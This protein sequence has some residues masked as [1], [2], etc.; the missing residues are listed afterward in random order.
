MANVL[1]NSDR[2]LDSSNPGAAL[3]LS[4]QAP[5]FLKK[6]HYPPPAFPLS[7][8]AASENADQWGT[9]EQLLL[10]CLRTGDD[11]S[12]HLCLDRLT[13]RFG[14][15]N[16]RIMGLRGLYQEATAKDMASLEKVLSEYER[17]LSENP[18]N[19]P[20]L[21]RRVAILRSMSREEDAI[22]AL[23]EF[24]EAFPTDAEA[25]CE[26]ADL[27]Q[28][29][30]MSSQAIFSLEEALLITPNSWNL[31]ARLGE[32]LYISAIASDS[33]AVLPGL[34]V[35]SIRH[36]CRSIELC[37]D[38]L[39]GLYGLILASS[40]LIEHLSVQ[41]SSAAYST[42]EEGVPAKEILE[43]LNDMAKQ[44]LR[45]LVESRLLDSE[46]DVEKQA[47]LIAA[48]ELLQRKK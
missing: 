43:K 35:M 21:K 9:F 44:R 38:Y 34:L 41:P 26:L 5:V 37:D 15:S 2:G 27:Y 33:K 28:A 4:Q 36:F 30:G 39:R 13:E 22:S 18:V 8:A 17:I 23:V 14:V 45:K 32:L 1:M 25:W 11:K 46:D 10:A 16:E 29:Q 20:V 42:K 31:H 48:Q 19:V 3:R 12:A 47:E 7:L 6:Y 40:F 24:L